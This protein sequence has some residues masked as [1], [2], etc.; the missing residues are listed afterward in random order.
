MAGRRA[1]RC[2]SRKTRREMTASAQRWVA[3]HALEPE[4]VPSQFA[5]WREV[6]LQPGRQVNRCLA[7]RQAMDRGPECEIKHTR[8]G[9]AF[10]W[11]G[12][13]MPRANGSRILLAC[14]WALAIGAGLAL[15]VDAAS[16]RGQ[17]ASSTE[18]QNLVRGLGLGP[19]L[20][21]SGC[22]FSF[23]PRIDGACPLDAGPVP[24][25]SRYCA[26]HA[27]SIFSLRY[28]IRENASSH[29]RDNQGAEIP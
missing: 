20:S 22:D 5:V 23:D 6:Q 15:A 17:E 14:L 13:R 16:H 7:Q 9:P 27:C 10:Q 4:D 2:F 12:A 19:S 8:V 3:M 29:R 18:F 24:G 25:G 21:L 28:T 11:S 26:E 1:V